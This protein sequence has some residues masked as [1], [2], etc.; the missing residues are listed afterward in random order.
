MSS[1]R[2]I[3]PIKQKHIDTWKKCWDFLGG[4]KSWSEAL[5]R[6]NAERK[7]AAKKEAEAEAEAVAVEVP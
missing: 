2:P 6:H 7:A 3:T 4:S 5:A 1:D